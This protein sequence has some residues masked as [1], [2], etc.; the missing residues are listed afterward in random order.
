MFPERP[1]PAMAVRCEPIGDACEEDA[2]RGEALLAVDHADPLHDAFG[3]R[4]GERE[5]SAAVV[6]RPRLGGRDGKQVLYEALNVGLTPAI[7]ALPAGYDVL[8]R[9]VQKIQERDVSGL[10]R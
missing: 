10:H 6:S 5:Q 4:F 1:T 9:T 2:D 3:S 7:A 8:N